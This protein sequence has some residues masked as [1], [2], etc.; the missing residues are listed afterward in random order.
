MTLVSACVHC[1]LLLLLFIQVER[2][3]KII[4]LILNR[5]T[6]RWGKTVVPK[7][8]RRIWLVSHM[9]PK[10]GSNQQRRDYQPIMLHVLAVLTIRS[11]GRNGSRTIIVA[12]VVYFL[13]SKKCWFIYHALF[14]VILFRQ[15]S[16]LCKAFPGTVFC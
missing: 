1:V 14:H 13:I 11:G 3:K 9:C 2:P 15:F 10:K 6:L 16:T 8:S 4:S 5:I 7:N 12:K